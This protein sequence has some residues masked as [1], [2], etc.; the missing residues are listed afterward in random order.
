MVSFSVTFSQFCSFLLWEYY[1]AKLPLTLPNHVSPL[2]SARQP[3]TKMSIN[4]RRGG[5]R[6]ELRRPRRR[7]WRFADMKLTAPCSKLHHSRRRCHPPGRDGKCFGPQLHCDRVSSHDNQGMD[8]NCCEAGI[9]QP[10][11]NSHSNILVWSRIRK[12]C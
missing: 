8:P 3:C 1:G 9:P 7:P 2:S 4:I 11:L 12:W 6:S 5:K 10:S